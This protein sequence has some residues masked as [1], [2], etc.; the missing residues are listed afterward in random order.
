MIDK[1]LEFSVRQRVLVLMGALALLLGGL[2]SANKLPMDAIPDITGVQVQVNTTVPALAPDEV[3]KLVTVPLEMALGGV[4]GVTEMRSLSR[5]GLSQITLQ[6]TD[7]SDIYRARQLV[8]ERL[9]SALDSLPAGLTPK[10]IPI[11]T[12]LGEV[13][14]YT[15]DYAPNAPSAPASREAQLMEL[16]EIQEYVIK[17]QLRTVP[18]VAEV[19]AYG[20]YQKQIVVQPDIAKLRDAGLT[21]KD[22]AKVVGENVENA[23]GGIVNSGNEQLV[24]RGVG[25][26]VSPQEIVELPVK[27]AAGVM[28]MRVKDFADV[29]IGHAF[30]T[31]AATHSGQEAVLGVAMMLM[32]ENSHAVAERVAEKVGEIQKQLPAGVVIN[33]EYN[34][35]NLVHRTIRTVSMNLFEGAL[36]VTAVLLLLLGNWRAALIVATAIPLA[37]LFA[38]TGMT[39]FG[40]S[41]NLMSLGAIDF[42]LII[43]GAVVIVE[44]VVRQLGTKQREIG[45]RLTTE[46]RLHVVLTASKQVGTPM[47]FGVSIIT[48]VYLPILALS[49]V[50]GKMFHPMALTVMLALGGSLVLALTLMPALCSFLLRGSIAEGD[51]AILR[52]VKSIYSPILRLALR[53]RWLV[54]LVATVLFALSIL[55]FTRLGADFIPK[56][57]EGAFTMMVYRASSINLD[58]SVEQQRKT[59]LEIRKRVPEVTHV[60]SRIGSAEIATDPMPPS[61]CDFYIFYKPSSEWRKIDNRRITKEELAK[62]ITTEIET[63]NPG[64]HVMIAQP[65]EMRFN[66][67]LE[68]IRADIA[69]KIFGNNYDVLERLGAEVKE[70]LEQIPGTREGEGEV[71][72]ETT[73][74]APMLEIRVKRDVLAKYNLHAGDVNETIAAALG[75]QT[76]GTMIEGNRR[77]EIVV[78]LAEVDRENLETI[79]AL[80]VRVGDAGIL[81]LGEVADIE[82]VKTVSPILRDSAQRRA[83]LM[84]NLRGRDVES[85]VREADAR[86]RE[87]VKLPEGYTLEFGGQFENLREAK[88]RLAIVVP[89]ALVFIFVLIFMAFGSVR[90]ALLVYSGVPLAVTGGVVAL[91]LR[92]MPFSISAAV[93]FIALSGVAVLNGVVMIAYF[94]QLREGGRDVR[95]AVIEGSLTRLRPVLMTAAVAAFGFI[96]MALST[97]AGAEV[98]R[99]L[100]TVVIGGIISSTFLTLLLLPVLYDWVERRTRPNEISEQPQQPQYAAAK[101]S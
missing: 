33:Q 55:I 40:I 42:G 13:F 39:R 73:G 81:P 98:Q 38:I 53:L 11:T 14:Y 74:R 61:D 22:L 50:E 47:F 23:G 66:E 96:P 83:A 57:D 75:G 72:Y 20:G 21:V 6:F 16:W 9:Q 78:R 69:V 44:N 41:G 25:R 37:F 79:C 54:V 94:N 80:P 10:L 15:I 88:A 12:G 84:V 58:Q 95:S 8:T 71:E 56:L 28:P 17:P 36:L 76:V 89:A 92:N 52:A 77:F 63:L 3:E 5:F 87:H 86:V 60:F 18:G 85:W 46:E 65:V 93:G 68:G 24:I 99:P 4:A 48:I 31:G 90:Q 27:F 29:E 32:G 30:R 2:W 101:R 64:A 26:V 35:K 19:N 43:D 91:W 82:Q 59:E 1:I 34:R 67:M 70:V 97:S 62:I 100:A 51:N 49:G 7:K 45:R